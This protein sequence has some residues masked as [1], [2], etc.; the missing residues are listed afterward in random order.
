M[1]EEAGA[2]Y[3]APV[4]PALVIADAE[5]ASAT[6][7]Y[8][9]FDARLLSEIAD[10]LDVLAHRDPDVLAAVEDV[11]RTLIWEAMQEPPLVRLAR[12]AQQARFY[13]R[14]RVSA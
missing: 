11:D 4:R 6:E 5:G 9:A 10:V 1:A 12:C 2:R 8:R 7:V 14:M 3:K 13:A